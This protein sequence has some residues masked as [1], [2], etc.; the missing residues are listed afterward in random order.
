MCFESFDLSGISLCFFHIISCGYWNNHE[1]SFNN[2]K[3]QHIYFNKNIID[4]ISNISNI[5]TILK[6]I[7]CNYLKMCNLFLRFQ[8][9]ILSPVCSLVIELVTQKVGWWLNLF[10]YIF[11]AQFRFINSHFKIGISSIYCINYSIITEHLYTSIFF[12]VKIFIPD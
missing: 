1:L 3:F 4:K 8:F 5:I 7:L 10:W 2:I 9:Y 12:H 6:L 11:N